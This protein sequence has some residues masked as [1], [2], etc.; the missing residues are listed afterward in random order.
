M[1]LFVH[2]VVVLTFLA[3]APHGHAEDSKGRISRIKRINPA[4]AYIP[5]ALGLFIGIESFADPTWHPLKYPQKDVADISGFFSD[6]KALSLDYHMTLTR[7]EHTTRDYILNH[8]L[9]RFAMKNS[10]EEDVVIV[11]FSG[12]GTLA[13]EQMIV[14]EDGVKKDMP[15]KRPYIVTSD[16]R[17]ENVADSALALNKVMDWFDRLISKRKVLILDM[18]HSGIGKSQL[19]PDEKKHINSAKGI[20]FLPMEDSWASIILSACPM[21]GTSYEDEALSNSVYTHFLLEGMNRGDLNGDGAIT[22]SEAHNYAID[23]TRAYTFEHKGYKQVPT[24]YSRILGRDPI[25]VNGAPQK[26]GEPV[27]FSYASAN[28][29]VEVFV[30]KAYKGMLPKGMTI[31]PGSHLIECKLDGRVVFRGTI[32]FSP[33]VDYML[34]QFFSGKPEKKAFIAVESGYRGFFNR[35]DVSKDLVPDGMVTGLSVYHSGIVR[36]WMALSGGLD[37]ARNSA[38]EQYAIRAGLKFLVSQGHVNLYVGPDLMYLDFR[39]ASDSVGTRNVD[40]HMSFFCPGAE[41]VMCWDVYQ[42]FIL[43]AGVRAFYFPY[44]INSTSKELISGQVFFHAGYSW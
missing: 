44:E 13:K 25:V 16:T 18:C 20:H 33:G 26:T 4:S 36:P 8:A 22:I 9:D 10:S 1:K 31:A 37:F 41:A 12:H 32:E 11:Y 2:I 38:L 29:G 39:Y 34:P 23:K 3:F 17:A 42:D 24:A 28:Q 30:N 14:F 15:L 40:Q 21:G 27:L 43:S 6:N 7:V 5:K 19:S 35:S